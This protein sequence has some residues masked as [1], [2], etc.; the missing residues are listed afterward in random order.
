MTLLVFAWIV[1]LFV[2][3]TVTITTTCLTQG[4]LNVN[5]RLYIFGRYVTEEWSDEVQSLGHLPGFTL[6]KYDAEL[7]LREE[8]NLHL[9][10]FITLGPELLL[11]WLWHIYDAIHN[12][13][14]S[15]C[16]HRSLSSKVNLGRTEWQR[17]AIWPMAELVNIFRYINRIQQ[18]CCAVS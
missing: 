9:S 11:N 13:C 17:R 6:N 8:L 14:P 10:G 3:T 1:L 5:N 12:P 4:Y 16:V 2:T 15:L 7:I 18:N